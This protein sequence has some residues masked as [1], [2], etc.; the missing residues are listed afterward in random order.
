MAK[1]ILPKDAAVLYLRMSSTKQDKSIPAQRDE[2]LAY[3]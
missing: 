2:L 3:A 1:G